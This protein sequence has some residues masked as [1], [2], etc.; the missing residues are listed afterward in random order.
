MALALAGIALALA[1]LALAAGYL[2]LAGSKPVLDGRRHV[3]GLT[4]PV[5][6]D[7]DALGVAVIHA[8]NRTDAAYALG[9]EHA[10]ERYFEMDLMRRVGAGELA[11]LVG[12]AALKLDMDHRRHRFRAREHARMRTLPPAQQA[13]LAAYTRGVNA[14]LAALSVRPWPY[15]LL[16]TRPKPWRQ[17][18]TLLVL[19]AMF[20]DLN[21]GGDNQRELD[22]ARATAALPA[23]LLRFLTTRD[24][25]WAA[26][27]VGEGAAVKMAPMPGPDVIDL[28]QAPATSDPMQASPSRAFPGSNN[29]AVGG[30]LT[31]AGGMLANDMHLG[32]RVPNIWF[33]AQ[34]NYHDAQGRAVQLNGVTLPGAPMLVAGSNGHIAWGFTNSYG[35]WMDDVRIHLD[36]HDVTRYRVPGGWAP[37]SIHH[38]VIHVKG[39]ADRTL[40]VRDTRWGPIMARDVDGTPLA[41]DWVA[42]HPRSHN[43][44]LLALETATSTAQ[45]LAI[46]PHI[47][48]PPQNL[49]VAD[50]KGHI[51]WTITGNALPL[52]HGFDPAL[53]ADFDTVGTGWTGFARPDQYPH[54]IDPP[55]ARLW[56]ANNR[57]TSGAW[58][59]LLGDGGYARGARA[60][61][62]RD[63]LRARQHFSPTDLLAIQ[64]DDRAVFLGRWH[65]LLARLVARH[66]TL[67]PLAEPVA[68]WQAR[69]AVDSVGYRVVRDFRGCVAD[70]TFAPFTARVRKRFSDFHWPRR[71]ETALWRMV[72]ERPMNLLDTRYASWDALLAGCGRKVMRH[73]SSLPGGLR[74]Q[75][76]GKRNTATI[77]Y[78]LARALPGW[79]GRWLDMPPDQLP[80]DRDMPRVQAPAFG[81]S[82]RFGIMPGHEAASYLHMPGGQSDNPLSPF[83]GAG[84]QA[85]VK[86][87]PTPLLPG[88]IRHHLT[89]MPAAH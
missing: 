76:W 28:R 23:P 31:G 67:R 16:R 19:D 33:R 20:F 79:L 81:A 3:V 26:P 84:H 44:D 32:L 85:W 82:E 48:I 88:P 60:R 73:L 89:L 36:P 59:N 46:G 70:A 77:D 17:E 37:L 30:A 71:S 21:A 14:G 13:V 62:I 66:D 78:P 57:T 18:D 74:A 29:F 45:A 58:L 72:S 68:H 24:D 27:L 8:N 56:T 43:L 7:R 55:G 10:Q 34:I 25:R 52:R 50:A 12:P 5:T 75:T 63:D 38:E 1:V 40:T 65:D 47:G 6:L 22:N 54:I 11:A 53:P 69:A 2:L 4:A 39:S 9:F 42:Q 15:L 80:G 86:G 87:R 35:D 83:Y 49:L 64:L 61:Q 51:G 41:V